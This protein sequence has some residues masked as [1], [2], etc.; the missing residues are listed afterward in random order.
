MLVAILGALAILVAFVLWFLMRLLLMPEKSSA[1]EVGDVVTADIN[2][3]VDA[4]DTQ[5]KWPR[6]FSEIRQ[7]DVARALLKCNCA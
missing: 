6:L 2:L 4:D 3:R 7:V 5:C 1:G